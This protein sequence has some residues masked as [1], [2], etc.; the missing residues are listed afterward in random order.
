[1]ADT[2][3]NAAY[4]DLIAALVLAR[5]DAGLT[6]QVLADRLEKPQSYIAK[7][8]GLERRIDVIEFLMLAHEMEID[9]IPIIDD[10]MNKLRG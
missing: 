8:E 1:M 9:P 5:K 7:I 4:K 2:I 3:H 10:A 6:Q